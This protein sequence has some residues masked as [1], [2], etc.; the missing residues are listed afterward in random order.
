MSTYCCGEYPSKI[1]KL[2]NSRRAIHITLQKSILKVLND[3][4]VFKALNVIDHLGWGALPP[5]L[6]EGNEH[7]GAEV[8][9]GVREGEAGGVEGDA[10]DGDDVNVD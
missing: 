4:K 9:A 3:L 2:C 7:E 6:I 1:Q 5:Q 10:V 8:G